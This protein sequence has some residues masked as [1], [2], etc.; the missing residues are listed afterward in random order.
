MSNYLDFQEWPKDW[1]PRHNASNE[2]CDMLIGPCACGATHFA[3][4]IEYSNGK[5][6]FY[7]P[8]EAKLRCFEKLRKEKTWTP[9]G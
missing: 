2:A 5:F 1:P 3:G 6:T 7:T 4:E 8:R 9:F